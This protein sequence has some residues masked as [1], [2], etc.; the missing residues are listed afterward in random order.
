[1]SSR[2]RGGRVAVAPPLPTNQSWEALM[3]MIQ[4]FGDFAL[5]GNVVDMAVGI[6]IGGAFGKIVSSLVNDLIMPVVGQATHD[7]DSQW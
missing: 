3:G 4:E 2:R 6:V 1:M 7:L 5:K